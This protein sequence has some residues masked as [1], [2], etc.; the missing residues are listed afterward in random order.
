MYDQVK[1][2]HIQAAIAW[3]GGALFAQLLA[4]RAE[5]STNPAELP[6]LGRQF[7]WFGMRYFLPSSIIL[8]VAGVILTLDRWS[9]GQTW[10]SIAML[11]WFVSILAGALYL[12]P[13]S[14]VVAERFEAEGPTSVAGRALLGRLFLISRLEL[15]G[16]A[17][18]VALM[19]FKPGAG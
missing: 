6:M 12:G 8:F 11:L 19:V 3:V 16:F 15:V 17:I 18:I 9:F 1:Y 10:I 14:K 2:I 4:F 13:K 5:R 7:E